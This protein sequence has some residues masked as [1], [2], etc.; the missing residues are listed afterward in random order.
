MVSRKREFIVD[1]HVH[2]I[3][4]GESQAIP[5]EI[6]GVAV[7]KGLDAICITE[8]DSL[9][10]SRPFE[11]IRRKTSLVI[12]RGV[13]LS[14]DAG[15]MLVY[16]VDEKDWNDWGKNRVSHAQELIDRVTRL[17]G[18]VIPAHP[19]VVSEPWFSGIPVQISVDERIVNLTGITALEVCNGKQLRWPRVCQVLAQYAKSAG[20][21][22]VGGSDAHFPHEVGRS[23]TVF[24]T[25][26]YSPESLVRALKS[27]HYYP[28]VG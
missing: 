27:Q 9:Y 3:Y 4:S 11:E 15:H 14:T 23:Y 7:A 10:A 21:G 1:M 22:S 26:I 6:V 16:G 28:R 17:G 20:I 18:V 19:W 25:P 8:H 5:E 12:I 2:S 13:E 24:K